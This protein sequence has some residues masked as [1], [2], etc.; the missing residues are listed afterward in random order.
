MKRILYSFLA[1]AVAVVA[2]AALF[3]A[4]A[5]PPAEPPLQAKERRAENSS[6][7]TPLLNGEKAVTLS[8]AAQAQAGIRVAPLQSV[9]ARRRIFVPAVVLS[10][11]SLANSRNAYVAAQATLE[12]A[13][14]NLGVTQGEYERLNRLYRDNQNA[15]QKSLQAAQ[16]AMRFDRIDVRA[17]RAQLSLQAGL[18]R[19]NW[20]S[21][22]ARWV[23]TSSAPLDRVLQQNA[24]LVQISLPPREFF[25][26]PSIAWLA[27]P[28]G[29][30]RAA[31]FVSPLPRVDP[32]VQGTSL[33]YLAPAG[34]GLAPGLTLTVQLPVGRR[35][36]GVVVPPS[37]VVW[38]E[39]QAWVYVRTAGDRFVRRP[40]AAEF[41]FGAGFFA[42]R[43]FSPGDKVVV[44]GAQILL[45]EEL[46][47]Q[48]PASPTGGGDIDD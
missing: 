20:G 44:E 1:A 37:A 10:A 30:H 45:S 17:A 40:L 32:R 27:L 23:T 19:Q 46:L 13:W 43:G 3:H 6:A 25:S 28:G 18:V 14:V 42:S 12:K 16:G 47:P 39:G 29:R 5:R 48:G 15:S 7:S 2:A 41:P 11:A 8:A 26:P 21:A 34:T 24:F 35:M 38:S 36:R 22:V 31:R 9:S 33:L 4:A